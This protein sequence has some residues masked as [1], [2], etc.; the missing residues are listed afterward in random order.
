MS[1]NVTGGKLYDLW[2]IA[3]VNLP[4][5]INAYADQSRALRDID[6]PNMTA[7]GPCHE[8]W[9][10]TASLLEQALC[11]TAERV[12]K[13]SIGVG[14][15]INAYTTADGDAVTPLGRELEGELDRPGRENNRDERMVLPVTVPSPSRIWSDEG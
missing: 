13:A 6:A 7:L 10:R 9:A 8:S 4:T 1:N 3:N 12:S 14:N 15:A 11:L 2:R 5:V